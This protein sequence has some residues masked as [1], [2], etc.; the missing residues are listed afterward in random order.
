M[1]RL[2]ALDSSVRFRLG[3]RRALTALGLVALCLFLPAAA[4]AQVGIPDPPEPEP[5]PGP[6]CLVRRFTDLAIPSI[7]ALQGPWADSVNWSRSGN[8][9]FVTVKLRPEHRYAANNE[10]CLYDDGLWT[11]Y[12]RSANLSSA[13]PQLFLRTTA[14]TTQAV[15]TV[16]NPY[17]WSVYSFNVRYQENV[18]AFSLA[19]NPMRKKKVCVDLPPANGPASGIAFVRSCS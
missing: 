11:S 13:T 17:I 18:G 6:S 3:P 2:H 10:S 14:T 19:F 5:E 16:M 8:T 7:V 12:H 4:S 15:V 9:F 1:N